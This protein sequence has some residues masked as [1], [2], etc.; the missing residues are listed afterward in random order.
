MRFPRAL[1]LLLIATVFL[2]GCGVKFGSAPE[3]TEFFK[4]LMVTGD[5]TAGA[6]LTAA[7]SYEQ[8]NPVSV[9]VKCEIRQGKN[10]VTELG[11]ETVPLRP[12][13][14]REATPFPGNY[15]F[16]FS[17]DQ[18][19]TYKAECFT[20]ADEDNFI[21]RTFTIRPGRPATPSSGG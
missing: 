9:I 21:L 12:A 17:L 4:S 7:V 13:G 3:G 14:N 6:P 10:L 20:P 11:G 2:A 8:N 15:S 1:P 5:L 16:D 19:G 18:P